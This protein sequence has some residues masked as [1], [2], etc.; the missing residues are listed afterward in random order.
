MNT[1]NYI[2][3]NK[4][5]TNF[6]SI[7]FGNFFFYAVQYLILILLTKNYS[8]EEVGLYIFV[9]AFIKPIFIPLNLQL[10]SL[11]VTE[12]RNDLKIEDY[13]SLRLIGNVFTFFSVLI[14]AYLYGIVQIN[15]VIL[16]ILLKLIESQSEM[17]HAVFQKMQDMV[18]IGASRIVNGTL[19]ILSVF[20]SIYYKLSFFNLILI[21]VIVSLI[22][23][24]FLDIPKAKAKN[25]SFLHLKEYFK[26]SK[27]K[28]IFLFAWPIFFLE[29]VSKYYE[30]FPNLSVEKYFGLEMLA[31]FGSIVYFK[32]I[33]GQ[34]ITQIIN[35]IEPKMANLW[36][37]KLYKEFNNLVLKMV[38]LGL[39]IG[40]V[41]IVLLYFFGEH[42]LRI[43]FTEEY[44]N[45]NKLLVLIAISSGISYLYTFLSTSLT[46]MRKH[47][48]KVPIQFIGLVMLM[49][50]TFINKENLTIYSFINF[51]I[52][53]ELVLGVLY[54]SSYFYYLRKVKHDRSEDR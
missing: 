52:Y 9:L 54:Y 24:L 6:L 5:K 29:V 37:Q 18:F 33:G 26:I 42:I 46:C 53:T 44:A 14:A 30:S 36:K 27:M 8:K 21:W 49:F 51:L 16:L 41:I 1:K 4:T 12:T 3:N 25:P 22:V 43:L 31:I 48:I 10:R 32:A 28:I 47:Y 23:L 17:C 34:V 35:V 20:C 7:V 45:Y 13:H 50:L 38:F 40:A 15:I 39:V 2:E 11:Y 19:V